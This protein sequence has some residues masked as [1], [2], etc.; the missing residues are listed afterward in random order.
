MHY[1][2]YIYIYEMLDIVV[3]SVV[4]AEFALNNYGQ[5]DYDLNAFRS[6]HE[7]VK[8]IYMVIEGRLFGVEGFHIHHMHDTNDNVLTFILHL[9]V[10]YIW[11]CS[12]IVHSIAD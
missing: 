5:I 10:Y 8:E 12:T 6:L 3:T 7:W 2:I 4:L 11:G 9:W 1:L